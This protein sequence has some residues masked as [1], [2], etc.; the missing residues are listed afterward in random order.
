MELPL[1]KITFV[2]IV[3][4]PCNFGLIMAFVPDPNHEWVIHEEEK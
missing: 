3:G 2:K 1:N 4:P